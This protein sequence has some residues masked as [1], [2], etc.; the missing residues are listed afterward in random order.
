MKKNNVIK[1]GTRSM[2]CKK[3]HYFIYAGEGG[4]GKDNM[5]KM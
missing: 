4:E 2:E 5:Y 1:T 3:R